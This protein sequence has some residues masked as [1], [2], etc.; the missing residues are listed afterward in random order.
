MCIFCKIVKDEIPA[1]KLYEDDFVLAFLD[2]SQA[3]KGHTLIISKQHYDNFLTCDKE[4]MH[5]IF[6]VAQDIA[7]QMMKVL[8]CKGINILSNVN[9]IAGQSV[10]HFHVHVIPRY[11]DSDGIHIAFTESKQDLL[12]LQT[13]LKR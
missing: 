4:V 13:L 9:E 2:I 5:H 8:N 6:D 3:T 1:Y 12:E 7:N 10:F 11:D